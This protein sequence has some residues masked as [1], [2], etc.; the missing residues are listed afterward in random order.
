MKTKFTILTVIILIF[1][2]SCTASLPLILDENNT[3]P[4]KVWVDNPPKIVGKKGEEIVLK[5][6][7]SGKKSEFED[8]QN[9]AGEITYKITGGKFAAGRHNFGAAT[10]YKLEE[11]GEF[12][13]YFSSNVEGGNATGGGRLMLSLFCS[14]KDKDGNKHRGSLG[15]VSL[16]VTFKAD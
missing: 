14:Y 2:I 6:D 12:K 5:Y 1:T 7:W 11:K 15:G 3:K 16:D 4:L 8:M 10:K 9:A 13:F